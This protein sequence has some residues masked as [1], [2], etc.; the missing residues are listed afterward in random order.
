MSDREWLTTLILGRTAP[1]AADAILASDWLA[2]VKA[3]AKAEGLREFADKWGR[4]IFDGA[5][6]TRGGAAY[7]ARAEAAL[8]DPT[9]PTPT[10]G[11]QG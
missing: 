11:D 9:T 2:R 4:W 1:R 10:E 5:P 3:E 8:V 7:R 6:Q